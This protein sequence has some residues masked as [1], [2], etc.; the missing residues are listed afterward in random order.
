MMNR[1]LTSSSHDQRWTPDT[2]HP[3][4]PVDTYW[5][6]RFAEKRRGGEWFELSAADVK[7]FRRRKFM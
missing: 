5:H 2:G 6:K 3:S 7:A 4:T 1:E